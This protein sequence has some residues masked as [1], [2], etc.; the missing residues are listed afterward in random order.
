MPSHPTLPLRARLSSA[1]QLQICRHHSSLSQTE[2]AVWAQKTLELSSAP[3]Q[4]LIS[5]ILKQRHSLEALSLAA[6]TKKSRPHLRYPELTGTKRVILIVKR[7][8]IVIFRVLISLPGNQR[9]EALLTCSCIP[10]AL[11][12]HSVECIT[13]RDIT[14][15][16]IVCTVFPTVQCSLHVRLQIEGSNPAQD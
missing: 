9:A 2:L 4:P 3:S 8:W 13:I 16:R 6:L 7:F 10:S 1:Q 12:D 5:K 15:W 14:T 11:L